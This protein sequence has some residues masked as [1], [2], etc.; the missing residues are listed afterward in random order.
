MFWICPGNSIDNNREVFVI[1][2]QCLH[3]IK[4]SSAS[5]TAPTA[6][7]LRV[8]KELGG[9]GTADPDWPKGYSIL[10]GIMLST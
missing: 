4:A 1:A 6:S 9:A 5:H 8:H 3:S 10:Y 2:E 7:G